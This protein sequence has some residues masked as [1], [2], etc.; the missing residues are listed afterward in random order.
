MKEIRSTGNSK[1]LPMRQ[2]STSSAWFS[3]QRLRGSQRFLHQL[4]WEIS[5]NFRVNQQVNLSMHLYILACAH[6]E[7]TIG[8]LS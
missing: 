1:L 4:L 8:V 5:R 7:G 3:P 2:W 6:V